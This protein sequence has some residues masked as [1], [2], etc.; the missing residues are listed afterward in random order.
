MEWL[1]RLDRCHQMAAQNPRRL[2][3]TR[4]NH[5]S[6]LL[7]YLLLLLIRYQAML[8]LVWLRVT[9]CHEILMLLL[10]LLMDWHRTRLCHTTA[11]LLC[12]VEHLGWCIVIRDLILS[13]LA[14]GH[15]YLFR[16]D[17]AGTGHELPRIVIRTL[18][19]GRCRGHLW[20][21][22]Y[23]HLLL[24][25]GGGTLFWAHWVSHAM[26]CSLFQLLVVRVLRF[27]NCHD[28]FFGVNGAAETVWRRMDA[29]HCHRNH[30]IA[31]ATTIAI[32]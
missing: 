14:L 15:R 25:V 2:I 29:R 5:G 26:W 27:G 8:F 4:A 22:A 7:L 11:S 18:M 30:H 24:H 6:R 21:L 31:L 1:F 28:V 23:L 16:L 20:L 12:Q 32:T 13:K 9:L 19:L 3:L 10:L 17:A